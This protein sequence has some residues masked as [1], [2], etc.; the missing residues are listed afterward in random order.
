MRDRKNKKEKKAEEEP[1]ASP[2]PSIAE[3]A[4]A[5]TVESAQPEDG[6]VPR[7]SERE[8]SVNQLEIG[9]THRRSPSDFKREKSPF[10]LGDNKRSFQVSSAKAIIDKALVMDISGGVTNIDEY[11]QLFFNEYCI[12]DQ[13]TCS[14][15]S[16]HGVKIIVIEEDDDHKQPMSIKPMELDEPV[17]KKK[18]RLKLKMT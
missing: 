18:R 2:E 8:K 1:A 9:D 14:D 16:P 6:L 11:I 7:D 3:P 5:L 13:A 4:P 10:E 12:I 15:V 17:D